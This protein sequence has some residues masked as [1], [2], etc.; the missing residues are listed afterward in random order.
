MAKKECEYHRTAQTNLGQRRVALE[1]VGQFF[2]A[3]VANIVSLKP[4]QN[5]KSDVTHNV[6]TKSA[7]TTQVDV[8]NCCVFREQLGP[9]FGSVVKV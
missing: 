5:K 3:V 7:L 2:G 6:Q 8:D 9:R 4:G 1:R